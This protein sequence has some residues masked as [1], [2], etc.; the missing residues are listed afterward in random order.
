[1]KEMPRMYE[2]TLSGLI[3]VGSSIFAREDANW[4]VIKVQAYDNEPEI[5]INPKENFESKLHYYSQ[6]YNE[7]LT[8]KN[9]ENIKIIDY[10]FTVYIQEIIY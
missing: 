4:M 8:L 10:D 1:M 9:N 7:D 5:I 3:R 6:A 2:M